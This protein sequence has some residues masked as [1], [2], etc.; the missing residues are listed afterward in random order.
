MEKSGTTLITLDPKTQPGTVERWFNDTTY[1]TK[2]TR[3]NDTT[4]QRRPASQ[5]PSPVY[6]VVY[7]DL[8]DASV[9]E[10]TTTRQVTRNGRQLYR[11]QGLNHTGTQ[12]RTSTLS[13]L[14]GS[15]G[16]I[17]NYTDNTTYPAGTRSPNTS[18]HVYNIRIVSMN[19]SAEPPRPAWVQTAINRTRSSGS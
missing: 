8:E 7:S 4:Y 6:E 15:Q 13:L 16:V 18:Y 11:I 1:L 17:W 5:I 19:E 10:N 2:R 9:G 14:A 12:G 3:S